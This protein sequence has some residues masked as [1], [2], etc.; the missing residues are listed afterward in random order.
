VLGSVDSV[1]EQCFGDQAAV[2]VADGNTYAAAGEQVEGHLGDAARD[3]RDAYVYPG[4]PTLYAAHE[5]VTPL[6]EA[7]APHDVI[8]VAVGAGTLN[9]IVKRAAHELERPYMVVATAASMDGYSSFGASLSQGGWKQTMTCPAPRAVVADLG[10]L[11]HA[12]PIM[13]AYGYGDLLGKVPAGADWQLADELGVEPIDPDVWALVQGPLRTSIGRPAALREGDREAIEAL[14]DGLIMSGLAM[15]A[16]QSSRPASG[17]EHQFSHMWEM[18]GHG[19]DDDPPLSHGFKVGLGSIAVAALYERLLDRDLT[20]L[21]I[22]A[23]VAAWPSRGAVER[24]ARDA[25]PLLAEVAVDQTAA[26][27]VD[28]DELR[29]RLEVV[30]ERWPA[31][32]ERLQS[33]LLP[34]A[35]LRDM[36]DA[37]GCPTHPAHIKLDMD[38]FKDSYRRCQMIRS[39]YTVLDFAIEAGV[40]EDCVEELFAPGG[41]WFEA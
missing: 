4:S 25:H 35:E 34:A 1:F 22:D 26:K 38:A 15:Q 30:R 2:V 18:E 40:F 33:Q 32:R 16:H 31:I 36:L 29:R 14:V 10:V 21:D 24:A 13:A 12:P 3:L 7:L 8:P 27:Y 9:D 20:A 23:R 11:Q 41:Y 6:V 28:G 37:A 17:A 5:N 39:R 19:R